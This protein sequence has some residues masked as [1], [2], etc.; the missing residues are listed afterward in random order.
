MNQTNTFSLGAISKSTA[1]T[2]PSP[3]DIAGFHT[4]EQVRAHREAEQAY[5]DYQREAAN[6]ALIAA[7]NARAR[8]LAEANREQTDEEY[9]EMRRVQWQAQ[10]DNQAALLAKERPDEMAKTAYLLSSPPV[11]EI[12]VRNE[13]AALQLVIHWASRNYTLPADGFLNFGNGVFHLQMTAPA[14]AKKAAK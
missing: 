4:R 12:L 10:R 11:A 13:Y 3:L 5:Y 7:E 2:L 14:T 9:D 1:P 6:E 8:D